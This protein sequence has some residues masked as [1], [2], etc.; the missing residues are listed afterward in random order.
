MTNV[1]KYDKRK[2]RKR[3]KT[4]RNMGRGYGGNYL[5]KRQNIDESREL[6]TNKKEWARFVHEL[7]NL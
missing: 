5:A 1:N 4:M 6:A 2:F 3:R 7:G